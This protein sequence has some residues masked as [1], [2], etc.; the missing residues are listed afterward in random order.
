MTQLLSGSETM[1]WPVLSRPIACALPQLLQLQLQG[2]CLRGFATDFKPAGSCMSL[3]LSLL[4]SKI[5]YCSLLVLSLMIPRAA[6]PALIVSL[7]GICKPHG[8]HPGSK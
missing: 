2:S 1:A 7:D 5:K 4:V 3:S 8:G 6:Q